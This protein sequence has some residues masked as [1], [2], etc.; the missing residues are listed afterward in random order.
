MF[1]NATNG[2]SLADIAAAGVTNTSD[3]TINVQNA[4]L[5]VERVA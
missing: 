1:N 5:I 3:Q 4:N 2:Y